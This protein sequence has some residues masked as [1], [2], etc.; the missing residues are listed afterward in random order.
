MVKA[1]KTQVLSHC[2]HFLPDSCQDAAGSTSLRQDGPRP[3]P[4]PSVQSQRSTSTK[5]PKQSPATTGKQTSHPNSSSSVAS[6][7][8]TKRSLK[9]QAKSSPA[10]R[11]R[12]GDV[13]A[14]APKKPSNAF[15]W[16]CQEH[17]GS[18][19]DRFRGEGVAG[20][21]SLTKIL[22]Q[23]WAETPA[24]DKQVRDSQSSLRW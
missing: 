23:K 18:F 17:R 20:Q 10:S 9:G 16:F 21:H 14:N 1:L 4:S 15:F 13:D 12:K 5:K 11:R 24:E 19:E 3:T 8:S 7:K 2:A 6:P 22:A